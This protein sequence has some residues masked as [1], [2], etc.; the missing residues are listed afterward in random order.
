VKGYRRN[1]HFLQVW[2][3]LDIDAATQKI[4]MRR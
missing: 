4:F 2:R 1:P 3:F